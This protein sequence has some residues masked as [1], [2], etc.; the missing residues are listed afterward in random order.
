MG[1]RR[2]AQRQAESDA[3]EAAN[4]F[5]KRVETRLEVELV[6]NEEWGNGSAS[7]LWDW[8]E[9]EFMPVP[10]VTQDGQE[11]EF[12]SNVYSGPLPGMSTANY[13]ETPIGELEAEDSYGYAEISMSEY[14]FGVISEGM[15]AEPTFYLEEGPMEVDMDDF[16]LND[17]EY[18]EFDIFARRSKMSVEEEGE[19]TEQGGVSFEVEYMVLG[20]SGQIGL[21]LFDDNYEEEMYFLE[22]EGPDGVEVM[23]GFLSTGDSGSFM[24][25]AM[26]GTL[27]DEAIVYVDGS[28]QVAITGIN[29][30]TNFE[31]GF[32]DVN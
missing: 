7:D 23:S 30:V 15:Y 2:G 19:P 10:K 1:T 9:E 4:P 24:A 17:D 16:A 6:E 20:G 18:L 27:F 26:P 31:G 25:N 13:I 12:F 14:G 32:F 21:A 28:I 22:S 29:V 8:C 3:F 11:L 5:L